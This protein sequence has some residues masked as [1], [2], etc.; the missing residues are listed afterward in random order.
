MSKE[1]TLT[2]IRDTGLLA[3]L[4][5]PSPEL[6]LKMV[7][8]LIEGG[9]RGIEITYTTPEADRVVRDLHR[10]HED[11][12]LLGMGT[13]TEPDHAQ[14]AL[15]AGAAFIVSPHCEASLAKAMVETGLVVMLGA[16][17][18]SEVV[19]SRQLGS[20]V[21]KL[22]PGSLTGPGYLRALHGP[23]PD[24]PLMPTGGVD[25]DNLEQ[26]FRA[27]AF[28]VGAGS[29]LCPRPWAEEGRFEEIT[30]RAERFRQVLERIRSSS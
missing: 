27:G 3:V 29:A 12:L 21:V 1:Q 17:T 30:A 7:E 23:F 22:F 4:R 16:L 18:P 28:A 25:L 20:D 10:E 26:W 6:T 8:A 2:A 9:V 5:G 15:E 11:K 19:R 14:R 24:L 13:L